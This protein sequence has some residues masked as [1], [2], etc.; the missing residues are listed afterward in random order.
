MGAGVGM[1][2]PMSRRRETKLHVHELG[3]GGESDFRDGAVE[4]G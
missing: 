2:V 1:G 4:S 3:A